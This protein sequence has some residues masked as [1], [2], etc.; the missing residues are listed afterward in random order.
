MRRLHI[1]LS[2]RF[3]AAARVF[4]CLS[5]LFPASASALEPPV[6]KVTVP[7]TL[8]TVDETFTGSTGKTVI[9]IQ[10]AHDSLEAQQNIARLIGVLTA[11]AGVKKVFE[12]GYEGPVPTDDYFGF[13]RGAEIR[14]KVSFF[15][16]DTLRLSGAEFAHVNRTRD[17]ELTGADSIRFH[18]EN[19]EWYGRATGR[20]EETEKN[21]GAL[22]REIENLIQTP[23]LKEWIKLGKR[24]GAGTL[25]LADY[26]L[27]MRR[28]DPSGDET[29]RKKY[30]QLGFLLE[31][32]AR[33]K[34][35]ETLPAVDSAGLY[36][37]IK[38]FEDAVIALD[39]IREPERTLFRYYR[40]IEL[41]K[42][43][44]RLEVTQAEYEAA[45]PLL[46]GFDTEAAARLT[47]KHGKKAVVFPR[48]W[49]EH[50]ASANRFYELAGER[51]LRVAA[52]LDEFAAGEGEETAILVFGGFHKAAIVNMLRERGISYLVV[53]PRI[54]EADPKH[55][56]IYR[57]MM[58]SGRSFELL[59]AAAR[60]SRTAS[61]Y[62]GALLLGAKSARESLAAMAEAAAEN[63][64]LSPYA[65][66][67]KIRQRLETL[68]AVRS[69]MREPVE[70]LEEIRA[71][72]PVIVIDG[73]TNTGKTTLAKTLAEDLGYMWIEYS[74]LFRA[75][76]WFADSIG[77]TDP[78]A[79]AE[80][81]LEQNFQL[82]PVG[83]EIRV[84]VNGRDVTPE[85][86]PGPEA[87][88]S[89]QERA[90][91]L[92]ADPRVQ[93]FM[94]ELFRRAAAEFQSLGRGLVVSGRTVGKDIF[95]EVP[96]KFYLTIDPEVAA[97]RFAA[98]QPA[99][100]PAQALEHIR[101]RGK[102]DAERTVSP[103]SPAADAFL[104]DTSGLSKE[105]TRKRVFDLL[106]T[107]GE[108]RSELRPLSVP[109]AIVL[110]AEELSQLKAGGADERLE[111]LLCFSQFTRGLT[112]ILKARTGRTCSRSKY[113]GFIKCFSVFR[114]ACTQ[115]FTE[116]SIRNI[117]CWGLC[118]KK[119]QAGGKPRRGSR[120]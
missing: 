72:H 57:S 78:A 108:A 7:E 18:L 67:Q 16:L 89:F 42:R 87:V 33:S 73:D 97:G 10:D 76:G 32:S 60:A 31:V 14:R 52:A 98:S 1:P 38:R 27:R 25:G 93:L 65:L 113:R 20:S 120:V 9:Y 46:T 64:A 45:E 12:E 55:R 23:S 48:R 40:E 88:L 39:T 50:L 59:P 30:P 101:L 54:K 24:R 63:P 117:W 86:F 61:Y 34:K 29:F 79:A 36:R 58:S 84:H 8:G 103:V 96:A 82:R 106:R 68:A 13:I 100:D 70:G 51:D 99:M 94:K 115:G 112:F 3:N 90:S 5:F 26:L 4:L 41:L 75:A 71:R 35:G 77:E 105:E 110:P 80:K 19:I 53:S 116:R 47:A 92:A 49:Q 107:P 43:L 66:E 15:L 44:N 114:T 56:E 118:S 102:I 74:W 119:F 69:E 17:F 95:P 22:Q 28:L 85:L 83:E 81:V 62:E 2:V 91:R 21:L 111:E 11:E 37:E 104:L 6:R 109:A